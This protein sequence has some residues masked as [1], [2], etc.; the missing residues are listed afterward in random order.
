VDL[1]CPPTVLRVAW[2]RTCNLMSEGKKMLYFV[3]KGE[4]K[5]LA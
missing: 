3:W 4:I 1:P 2:Q 5:C